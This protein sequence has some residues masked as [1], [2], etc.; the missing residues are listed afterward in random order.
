MS[1]FTKEF[2]KEQLIEDLKTST[3]NSS[4]MFEISEDTICNLMSMLTNAAPQLPQPAV[5]D[6]ATVET[7]YQDVQTNWQDAKMYAEGWNACRTAMLQGAEPVS[8]PYTLR[9]GR[10]AVPVEPTSEAD[11]PPQSESK[12]G[13]VTVYPWLVSLMVLDKDLR[14]FIPYCFYILKNNDGLLTRSD[15]EIL[16]KEQ[17]KEHI[18]D[19]KYTITFFGKVDPYQAPQQEVQ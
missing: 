18:G 2:T 12:D 1:T 17:V 19:R 5:P 15:F 14:E 10:V 8:Q 6:I 7:T 9:D 16:L 3:Q 11:Q 13:T 4:G